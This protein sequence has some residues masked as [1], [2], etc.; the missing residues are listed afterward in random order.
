MD[1][2][3]AAIATVLR[4]GHPGND[5]CDCGTCR[6][7]WAERVAAEIDTA[8]GGLARE[9]RTNAMSSAGCTTDT[10]T[11]QTIWHSDIRYD[12]RWVSDWTETSRD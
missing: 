1:D 9:Q 8:L 12:Q 7:I 4:R 2:A 5:A 6:A 10:K 11:G 3:R